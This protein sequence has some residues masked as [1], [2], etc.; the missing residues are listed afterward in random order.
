MCL[1][2]A[3]KEEVVILQGYLHRSSTICQDLSPQTLC[4][5]FSKLGD[6]N[7]YSIYL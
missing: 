2:A 1:G 7:S 3:V 5:S 4:P 6:Y